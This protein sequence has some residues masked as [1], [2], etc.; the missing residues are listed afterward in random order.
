[1]A[2]ECSLC[3]GWSHRCLIG[4]CSGLGMRVG[5]LLYSLLGIATLLQGLGNFPFLFS[6]GG[7]DGRKILGLMV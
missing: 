7:G 3:K 6:N 5:V 2:S 1:M 4:W